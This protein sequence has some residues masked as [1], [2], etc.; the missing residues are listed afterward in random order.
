M[1]EYPVRQ[2][3]SDAAEPTTLRMDQLLAETQAAIQAHIDEAIHTLL[4]HQPA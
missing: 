1:V 2:T 4:S 3:R